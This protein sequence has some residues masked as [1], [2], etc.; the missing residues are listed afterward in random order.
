MSKKREN[1]VAKFAKFIP[2]GQAIGQIVPEMN[3]PEIV[4]IFGQRKIFAWGVL[5]GETAEIE[6]A[7]KKK[8]WAEGFAKNILSGASENRVDFVDACY[9]STSPW[10]IMSW[11]AELSEKENLVKESFSQEKVDL[12]ILPIATDGNQMN[13]RNKMEY[14]LYSMS[15]DEAREKPEFFAK[16]DENDL[17]NG[18]KIFL[19]FH[20]RG[21]HGKIPILQSSIEK[22]ELFRRANEI[23]ERL[24]NENA[25]AFD[26]QSLLLRANKKGEVSGDLFE[27]F[28]PRPQMKNLSDELRGRKFS[29]SPN[30]FF[31]I[32]LPVYELA[33]DEISRNIGDDEDIID[34]YSGVGSIGL[35]LLTEKN[36]VVL[37]ETNDSA[38]AEARENVKL[39]AENIQK[40][41][42]I[43]H[44]KSEDALGEITPNATLIVDPPRAG[45]DKTVAEKIREIKPKRVIYLSCNPTTQARDIARIIGG[46]DEPEFCEKSNYEISFAKPFNFFPRTPHIENLVVLSLKN[47]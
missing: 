32:N 24:N 15:V 43:V 17:K 38:V 36:K 1:I 12:D 7:K 34:M 30:G 21:S 10:Q 27:N 11:G 45:L 42:K 18:K 3:S 2:G 19:A 25:N 47:D 40:N 33:L 20:K 6:I 8:N 23:I 26:F 13:Y 29:Y 4:Q 28:K 9:L 31:Q 5:P 22:P 41:V 39:L 46:N 16:F 37:V 35:S 14:S 44:A